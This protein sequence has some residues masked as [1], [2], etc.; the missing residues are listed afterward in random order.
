M[1]VHT[2]SSFGTC[3]T[4]SCGHNIEEENVVHALGCKWLSGLMQNRHDETADI[5]RERVGRLGFSSC[6]E[7]RYFRLAPRTPNLPQARWVCHCNLRPGP[8]HVL[9]DVSFIHPLAASYTQSAVRTPS[10]T[11]ALRNANKRQEFLADHD[12]PGYAFRAIY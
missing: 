9:A 2:F 7:G 4:C 3:W 5:L 1:R 6:Q 10:H 8:G 11:A 12:C